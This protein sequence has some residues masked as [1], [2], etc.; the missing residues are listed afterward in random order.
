M[1]QS[2]FHLNE[3]LRLTNYRKFFKLNTDIFN[4]L[5]D[6]TISWIFAEDVESANLKAVG[7]FE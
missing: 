6:W 5:P 3:S 4:E 7:G 2:F 1:L